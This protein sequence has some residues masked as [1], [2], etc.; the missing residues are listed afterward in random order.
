MLFRAL[1]DRLCGTN[2]SHDDF[3]QSNR[4]QNAL[5]R[6]GSLIK[7][8]LTLFKSTDN[9]AIDNV[10]RVFPALQ[11]LQLLPPSQEELPLLQ[12]TVTKLLAS[13]HWHVR[14]KAARTLSRLM[15]HV[16]QTVLWVQYDPLTGKSNNERHGRCLFLRYS[17][18]TEMSYSTLDLNTLIISC[19]GMMRDI[20]LKTQSPANVIIWSAMIDLYRT[21]VIIN[22]RQCAGKGLEQRP[23][24]LTCATNS[25]RAI[26]ADQGHASQAANHLLLRSLVRTMLYEHSV[27]SLWLDLIRS[28]WKIDPDACVALLEECLVI[29]S[30]DEIRP[31]SKD[32]MRLY[33]HLYIIAMDLANISS[34]T[35]YTRVTLLAIKVIIEVVQ[36]SQD[37]LKVDMD[38]PVLQKDSNIQSTPLLHDQALIF[39]GLG[40]NSRF[41]SIQPLLYQFDIDPMDWLMMLRNAIDEDKVYDTRFAAITA[42][43]ML[44]TSFST[45][46]HDPK[47]HEFVIGIC[48]L[49][50]DITN[51]DDDEIR[52][53]ASKIAINLIAALKKD[54]NLCS[55]N[56]IPLESG[57]RLLTALFDYFSS[58]IDV[59]SSFV[60][61][62]FTAAV[63]T[64]QLR[65]GSTLFVKEKQNLYIDLVGEIKLMSGLLCSFEKHDGLEKSLDVLRDWTSEQLH[66]HE[67]VSSDQSIAISSDGKMFLRVY[68]L[69]KAC[70]VLLYWHERSISSIS[71]DLSK[72]IKQFLT[73]MVTQHDSNKKTQYHPMI[74]F[75]AQ[76]ILDTHL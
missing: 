24:E 21:L 50:Y 74:L 51:D 27:A 37:N 52:N 57:R 10:E 25:L 54:V 46:V 40:L 48:T 72:D 13:P 28:L 49:V 59:V 4:N 56:Y 58:S 18:E 15:R 2:Q 35:K 75:E 20:D 14:D 70:Q 60:I 26:L 41:L 67:M 38:L 11:L 76:S 71:D 29:L 63:D 36:H 42:I 17:L 32:E 34:N 53:L 33:R 31:L 30:K 68:K 43:N 16:D 47:H 44:M 12:V 39:I 6:H 7:L 19:Q 5:I 65:T 66:S 69:V 45:L 73:K 55:R 23:D 62:K 1:L 8:V 3:G 64:E 9:A 61:S 22:H